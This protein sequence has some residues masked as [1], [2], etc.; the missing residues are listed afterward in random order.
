M[1]PVQTQKARMNSKAK[2]TPQNRRNYSFVEP[3]DTARADLDPIPLI[4]I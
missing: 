3:E 4:T 1:I 2:F